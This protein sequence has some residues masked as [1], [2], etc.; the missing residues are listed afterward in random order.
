[1]PEQW[2]EHYETEDNFEYTK[3]AKIANQNDLLRKTFCVGG[4]V[5]RDQ[6]VSA[7][8]TAQQSALNF[9]IQGYEVFH[10]NQNMGEERNIGIVNLFHKSFRWK[11]TYYDRE[12]WNTGKKVNSEIPECAFSTYRV[13]SITKLETD[14]R[15]SSNSQ[16]I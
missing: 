10:P 4:V 5:E 1:M 13:L 12:E 11:I 15:S 14:Q 16:A 2:W 8:S 7:L 9:A 6:N 3:V